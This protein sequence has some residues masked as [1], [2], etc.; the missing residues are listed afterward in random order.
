MI[1]A[2][3][4]L[5]AP[6][7]ASSPIVQTLPPPTTAIRRHFQRPCPVKFS[8]FSPRPPNRLPR[9]R[10]N[11]GRLAR[12]NRRAMRDTRVIGCAR[13]LPASKQVWRP[14][15]PSPLGLSGKVRKRIGHW[16][17]AASKTPSLP[18]PVKDCAPPCATPKVTSQRVI[19]NFERNQRQDREEVRALQKRIEGLVG[20]IAVLKAKLSA[21]KPPK[22]ASPRRK[23]S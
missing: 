17:A 5:R 21:S 8:L 15:P 23:V 7:R 19:D 20:E 6:P 4:G 2:A 1:F 11:A 16:T 22:A 14:R 3:F 9:S 18:K 10:G 13:R 12:L